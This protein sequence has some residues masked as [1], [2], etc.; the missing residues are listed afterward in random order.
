MNLIK[1][2]VF[3]F[4]LISRRIVETTRE[5]KHKNRGVEAAAPEASIK[6]KYLHAT[7]VEEIV[8]FVPGTLA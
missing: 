1:K 6:S 7:S 4:L 8:A 3:I 5:K 2:Y